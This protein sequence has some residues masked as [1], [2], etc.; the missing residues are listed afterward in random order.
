VNEED[1]IEAAKDYLR[2]QAS[3]EGAQIRKFTVSPPRKITKGLNSGL[4]QAKVSASF[5]R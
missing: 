5:R 1:A 2:I 3:I 4:W